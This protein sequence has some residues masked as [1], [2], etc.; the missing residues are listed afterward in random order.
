MTITPHHFITT[1]SVVYV[2]IM[3]VKSDKHIEITELSDRD[4]VV[5]QLWKLVADEGIGWDIG[6]WEFVSTSG[7][8]DGA[9]CNLNFNSIISRFVLTPI[10]CFIGKMMTGAGVNDGSWIFVDV[11]VA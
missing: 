10:E 3:C 6:E 9:V 1:A 2:T 5:C 7:T 4:E 8:N 11:L